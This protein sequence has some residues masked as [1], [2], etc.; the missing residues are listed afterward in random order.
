MIGW[1]E[2][3]NWAICCVPF[4]GLGSVGGDSLVF[5]TDFFVVN[6]RIKTSK[7]FLLHDYF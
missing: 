4:G 6:Q 5:V 2:S 7:A 3:S 1:P